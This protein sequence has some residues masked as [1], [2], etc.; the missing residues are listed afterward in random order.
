MVRFEV[1]WSPFAK[2]AFMK[3]QSRA[4]TP[5][6]LVSTAGRKAK[7]VQRKLQEAEAELHTANELLVQAVPTRDQE[8]IDAALEQNV[9]AEEKVHD[10]AQELEVVNALLSDAGET[11]QATGTLPN[12][13]GQTGQG[14]KSLIPHL[15]QKTAS[16]S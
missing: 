9:A 1:P 13:Q 11:A 10:A 16:S 6:S 12:A 8:S 3:A 2:E 7:R 4:L 5:A 15:N 14:A